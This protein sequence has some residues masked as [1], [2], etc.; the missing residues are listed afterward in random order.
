[1]WAE[2]YKWAIL[3][4]EFIKPLFSWF[5]L[6]WFYLSFC[7][8]NEFSR[9]LVFSSPS[10]FSCPVFCFVK[11]RSPM[12]MALVHLIL[13]LKS[14]SYDPASSRSPLLWDLEWL[15]SSSIWFRIAF[16][17][18]MPYPWPWTFSSI[19]TGDVIKVG[20]RKGCWPWNYQQSIIASWVLRFCCW[21]VSG[22]AYLPQLSFSSSCV[23]NSLLSFPYAQRSLCL[24]LPFQQSPMW[25]YLIVVLWSN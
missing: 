16:D 5:H 19:C 12:Q 15:V 3:T 25:S 20:P 23:D 22:P 7:C 9:S 1:M 6:I 24:Y 11:V 2:P 18:Q 10:S 4:S 8:L 21:I 14:S 17:G 13:S